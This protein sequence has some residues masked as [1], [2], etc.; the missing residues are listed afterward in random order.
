MRSPRNSRDSA[1]KMDNTLRAALAEAMEVLAIETGLDVDS[2]F[3]ER[4]LDPSQMSAAAAHAAGIVEGAGIALG[5]TAVELL[6][7]LT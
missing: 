5:L 7:E 1:W 3:G 2:L 4:V 6:D